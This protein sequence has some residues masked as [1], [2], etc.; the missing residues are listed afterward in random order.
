MT[1]HTESTPGHDHSHPSEALSGWVD[2][3]A[4]NIETFRER[5][6]P[7]KKNKKEIWIILLSKQKHIEQRRCGR[8]LR[9]NITGPRQS[10]QSNISVEA[11]HAYFI[12][13]CIC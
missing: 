8:P 6:P 7:I 10:I 1:V 12:I 4:G 11:K 13:T 5:P 2:A 9:I 3:R